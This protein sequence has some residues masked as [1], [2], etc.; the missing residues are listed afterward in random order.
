AR[1][2]PGECAREQDERA[3]GGRDALPLIERNARELLLR[4]L[5][6]QRAHVALLGLVETPGSLP[7]ILIVPGCYHDVFL[8]SRSELMRFRGVFERQ[9]GG[10][11]GS[12]DLCHP[13]EVAGPHLALMARGGVA[14][15][16]G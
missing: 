11:P 10:L 16:L 9:R 3:G 2:A 12:D 6:R 7:V 15:G 5:F 14:L 13:V 4:E 1:R 8:P